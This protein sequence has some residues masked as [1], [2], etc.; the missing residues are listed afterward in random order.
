MLRVEVYK[1]AVPAEWSNKLSKERKVATF[2][3]PEDASE[4]WCKT[5]GGLCLRAAVI[6]AECISAKPT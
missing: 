6:L 1:E 4:E 3:I 2:F 5:N